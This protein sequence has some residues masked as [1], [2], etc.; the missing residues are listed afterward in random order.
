MAPGVA[1]ARAPGSREV[2]RARAPIHDLMR[3]LLSIAGCLAL[4]ACTGFHA[5]R[6]GEI[7]RCP[8]PGEDDL[9]RWIERYD[10]RTVVCLR[11]D[12]DASAPSRRAAA[13]LAQFESVPMSATRA[14]QPGTLLRLWDLFDHAE[15]PI[16]L[17][18]RAGV[19]RT[20]LASALAVLHDTGDLA[21]ARSQ[22][23]LVPYGHLGMFGTQAMDE[24]LDAYAPHHGTMS[25]PDWV[26]DVYAAAFAARPGAPA[27]GEAAAQ[28]ATAR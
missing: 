23:A 15:R 6:D 9:A 1:K 8:Q 13:V 4:A 7:Y 26:K 25:F 18:C 5:V 20:G 28:S 27:S 11:G 17:H 22:L 12:G 16:L 19:D 2:G 24:V 3:R 10:I 14:P 21:Q